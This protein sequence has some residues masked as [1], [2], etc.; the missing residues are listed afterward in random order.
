MGVSLEFILFLLF[1]V[2]HFFILERER[3]LSFCFI[4]QM[5]TMA[6]LDQTEYRNPELSLR[7]SHG[8]Q[9]LKYLHHHSLPALVYTGSSSNREQSRNSKSDT[10]RW[11]Q[12]QT[13]RWVTGIQTVASLLG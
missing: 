13:L 3:L 2:I 10:L 6:K 8:C 9:P 1:L 7:L 11:V 5:P 12:N 4:T